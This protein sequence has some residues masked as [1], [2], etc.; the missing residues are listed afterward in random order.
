MLSKS[1]EKNFALESEISRLRHYVSVL[2]K[3]LHT[4][5]LERKY[6]ESLSL[7]LQAREVTEGVSEPSGDGV[8][9]EDEVAVF[10]REVAPTVAEAVSGVAVVPDVAP[11]EVVEASD[12]VSVGGSCEASDVASVEMVEG[13]LWRWWGLW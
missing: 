5:T 2:S 1:I 9:E 11:V 10:R 7:E 8:A 13:P 12:V 6:F 3:R 4:V